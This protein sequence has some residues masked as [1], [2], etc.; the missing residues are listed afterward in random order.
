MKFQFESAGADS[1]HGGCAPQAAGAPLAPVLA[2]ARARGMADA[3]EML[4]VAAIFIDEGGFALHI[5][6]LAR[7]RLGP[8]LWVDDGRL[9]AAD[10]E[11]DGALSAAIDSALT[12]G[13]PANAATDISFA[14]ESRGP[15]AV[16]VVAIAPEARD[17][18]QL[19]RAMVLIEE[20]GDAPSWLGRAYRVALN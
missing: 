15:V 14:S 3:F 16:K 8:Q 4:G 10:L 9:R 12:G 2:G 6:D 1:V 18:F 19:L 17:P 5:N 11:L 7:R 20:Q 13:A